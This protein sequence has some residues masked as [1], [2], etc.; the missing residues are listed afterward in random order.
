MAAISRDADGH[1]SGGPSPLD[2]VK[3]Y[4]C[5]SENPSGAWWNGG[6]PIGFCLTCAKSVIPH[7]VVDVID[8]HIGN[9]LGL[10]RSAEEFLNE[11]VVAYWK[12]VSLSIDS[13]LRDESKKKLDSLMHP[14]ANGKGKAT[15]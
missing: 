3:C 6:E 12:K 7:L 13:H 9:P 1:V 2:G 8:G 15:P 4:C 10:Y 14:V 5:R 11:F